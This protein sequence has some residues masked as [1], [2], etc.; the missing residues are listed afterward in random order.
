MN[1]YNSPRSRTKKNA[2]DKLRGEKNELMHDPDYSNRKES[3]KRGRTRVSLKS[4]HKYRPTLMH[5]KLRRRSREFP[6]RF[7]TAGGVPRDGFA[8]Q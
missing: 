2:D 8:S 4:D 5:T 1:K 3:V 6:S 7:S